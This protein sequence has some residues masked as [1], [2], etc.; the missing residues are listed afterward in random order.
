[1]LVQDLTEKIHQSFHH[2]HQA[3][4]QM[5]LKLQPCKVKRYEFHSISKCKAEIICVFAF[6][7]V[8]VDKKKNNFFTGGKGAGFTFW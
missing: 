7:Q 5:Q 1:M 6:T 8:V 2:R 4:Y 3:I